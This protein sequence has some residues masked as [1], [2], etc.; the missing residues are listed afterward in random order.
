MV[1]G[2]SDSTR[3]VEVKQA[4]YGNEATVLYTGLLAKS[5]ADQVYLH[6]G[7]GDPTH[8]QNVTTQRMD[9]TP[10]GWEKTVRLAE[11]KATFCFKDSAN[12]WDN[13]SGYNWMIGT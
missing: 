12:N 7:F 2:W 6:C 10:R 13:N 9:R 1:Q 8:W 11:N 3:G 5:G 4:A